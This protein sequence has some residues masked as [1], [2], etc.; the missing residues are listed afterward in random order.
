M[1]PEFIK[2]RREKTFS[3]RR[4]L[5]VKINDR[6]QEESQES[7]SL[8]EASIETLEDNNRIYDI[9]DCCQKSDIP[10]EQMT[11]I[12]SGQQLCPACARAFHTA[13]QNTSNL[14]C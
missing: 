9:C 3:K 2:K 12:D 5:P 11:R 6:I 10:N 1:I 14:S 8:C 7:T 4:R 13:L